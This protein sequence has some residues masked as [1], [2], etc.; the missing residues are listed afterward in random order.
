MLYVNGEL[1][2][3]GSGHAL[4]VTTSSTMA[5]GNMPAGVGISGFAGTIDE[6]RV[7]SRALTAAE[8][9]SVY[10]DN[11]LVSSQTLPLSQQ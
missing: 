6:V 11:S 1:K 5:I 10:K 4:P 9:L 2:A 7:I 8:I 3:T